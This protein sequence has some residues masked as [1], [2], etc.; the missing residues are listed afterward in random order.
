MAKGIGIVFNADADE[1]VDESKRVQGALGDIDDGLGDI[2][3]AAQDAERK[4]TDAFDATSKSAEDLAQTVSSDTAGGFD[5]L[6]DKADGALGGIGDDLLGI[7]G[8][9]GGVGGAVSSLVGGAIE[10]VSELITTQQEQAAQLRDNLVGAYR[11]AIEAGREYIDDAQ[12]VA[13]TNEIIF[14]STARKAAELAAAVIGVDVVTYI[15]AQA[16]S[17]T[18]LQ[19]VI[20][21]TTAAE[22]TRGEVTENQSK[23]G[24]AAALQEAA[25]IDAIRFQTERLQAAHEEGRAA[26]ELA[27]E[28]QKRGSEE[29]I[30]AVEAQRAALQA[31]RD[32]VAGGIPVQVLLDDSDLNTK[33][34]RPRT[35]RVQVEG[36]RNGER[37]I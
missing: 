22:Q 23:A 3:D 2:G 17:Y 14:D 13:A 4:Q 15:R 20:A 32:D 1:V 21:A 37:V 25:A 7:A 35:I 5:E 11:D 31:L 29:A 26:A 28:N 9:A 6:A 36:F 19:E 10:Y 30:V 16:G 27:A 24:Q 34:A 8:I 33:L 18:D 12:I